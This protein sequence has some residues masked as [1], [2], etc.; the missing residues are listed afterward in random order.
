MTGRNRLASATSP[1]LLQHAD[2]P[3]H[4]WPWSDEAF[5]AAAERQVPVFL[6][7]GYAACHW[8][9]VMA[10]ESF[11]DAQLASV[12]NDHFVAIK[13]DRE[14]RPDV[15][16]V[17]MQATQA[18]T[19]QGGWPMSVFLT[20]D[21]KPFY[22]GTYFPPTPRHGLPSFTQVLQAI[23]DAWRDRRSELLL[24]A[25]EIVRQLSQQAPFAGA[26][27]LTAADCEKALLA[28]QGE[29]DTTYGGFGRA[30]KFPPSMVLEALL[31]DGSEP[32]MVMSGKT[33]DAM[34]RGGIYDQLGGGFARYSVDAG[35]IVPHFEKMLYDNALL[36]AVYA[37]W[38]RRTGN[39][40]AE[41]IVTET[42]AWLLR[43]M[44]TE[45]GAFAS[46]L[47]ADSE[48]DHGEL[49]EGAYYVWNRDQL[50]AALGHEDA[51]WAAEVFSVTPAGTFEHGA[52]TLQLLSDHDQLR[53]ADVRKRLRIAREQRSRPGRDDKVVAAWNALLVAGLV[54]AGMIF[55][56][57]EW[58]QIAT[59]VAEHLWR[60]HWRN[61]RLRRT[62]RDG[63]VGDAF[64]ILED[65][66]AFA[67]AALGLAAA[68]TEPL[69][70]ARAEQLLEVIME[71]FDDPASGFFDTAAD[72]EQLYARPQDPTDNA[73][74]SGLSAAVHALRLMAELTGEDRYASRADQ[75]AASAGELVRRAPRFAGWLLADAISQTSERMPVEVAVVG[76]DDVARG[77]LVRL[78]H[79]LAPAGSVVVAG[80]PDQPGLALLADR[81]MINNRPTAYVCRHFACQ[82]PVTSPE[83]LAGQLKSS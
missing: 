2:N 6:S 62:S 74:P 20:P 1:Y 79:R 83:D 45:Q 41:R 73:T 50:Q 35:W 55:D 57:P 31:R 38:W 28:L 59:Q 44:G 12:I 60:L 17:Y 42:V 16:A 36:L 81:P 27:E 58:L 22:A 68:H 4:W 8:C 24:S 46:S 70:L 75:A 10:H 7:V 43:E 51:A 19:G 78:A 23:S 76:P 3:V 13:V 77:E 53:L 39:P 14:E 67:L 63:V 54:Q 25:S 56:R 66:A 82:L 37:H 49:R 33:L 11:E 26:A 47:D 5:A 52:S 34:A 40:L 64:G 48:D 80:M 32:S 9:H 69:W 30:P 65:Y 15:D 18:L 29:F 61:G 21:R 71:Q 72:A